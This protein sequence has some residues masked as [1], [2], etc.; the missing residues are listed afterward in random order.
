MEKYI[1]SFPRYGNY[2][3]TVWKTWGRAPARARRGRY[4]R[5]AAIPEQPSMDIKTENKGL[6]RTAHELRLL[7]GLAMIPPVE[8]THYCARALSGEA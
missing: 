6:H 5:P 1:A 3:S 4:E 8:A 7:R 2:F